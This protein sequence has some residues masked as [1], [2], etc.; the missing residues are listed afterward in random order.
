MDKALA[1]LTAVEQVK[2]CIIIGLLCVQGDLKSRPDM[3][4][5]ISMLTSQ[6]GHKEMLIHRPGIYGYR[7]YHSSSLL[8]K[9]ELINFDSNYYTNM[10]MTAFFSLFK[11]IFHALCS[12]YEQSYDFK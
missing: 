1:D 12:I 9:F 11:S 7:G 8:G 6:Q 5:V 4:C 3:E 10:L 2:I